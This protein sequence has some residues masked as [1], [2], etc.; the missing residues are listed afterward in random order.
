M[1]TIADYSVEGVSTELVKPRACSSLGIREPRVEPRACSLACGPATRACVETRVLARRPGAMGRNEARRGEMDAQRP[2]ALWGAGRRMYARAGRW[3][4]RCAARGAVACVRAGG[5][6]RGVAAADARRVK[7]RRR[8]ARAE[9]RR[10]HLTTC[11][12]VQTRRASRESL[13]PEAGGE[14]S[15]PRVARA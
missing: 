4:A 13:E 6:A 10:R 5:R 7:A 3:A 12:C 14:I 11:T 8:G 15:T 1:L 9:E 2:D